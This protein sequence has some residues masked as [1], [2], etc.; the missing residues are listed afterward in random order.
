MKFIRET[1]LPD[2]LFTRR[3]MNQAF[4][5]GFLSGVPGGLLLA[6]AVAKAFAVWGPK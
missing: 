5:L 4:L 2:A 3:D 1:E 6:V